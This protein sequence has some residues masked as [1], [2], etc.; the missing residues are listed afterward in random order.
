MGFSAL[1]PGDVRSGMNGGIGSC[2]HQNAVEQQPS[3]HRQAEVVGISQR[4][5]ENATVGRRVDPGHRFPGGLSFH[6]STQ[7][8]IVEDRDRS[9]C[10]GVK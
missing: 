9:I 3:E 6:V 10:R 2:R 7:H 1:D 5:V 8:G 4:G